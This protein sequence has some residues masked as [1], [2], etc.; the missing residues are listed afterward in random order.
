MFMHAKMG[1]PGSLGVVETKEEGFVIPPYHLA[2]IKIS[3]WEGKQRRVCYSCLRRRYAGWGAFPH[4]TLG[5]CGGWGI[6]L[7][8]CLQGDKARNSSAGVNIQNTVNHML[9]HA[10]QQSPERGQGVTAR[11]VSSGGVGK[12]DGGVGGD[13]NP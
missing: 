11:T 1:A 2:L 6:D 3:V 4:L 12:G 9:E 5:E 8:L 7:L 10:S 13:G